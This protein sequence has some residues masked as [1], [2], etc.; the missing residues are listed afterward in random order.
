MRRKKIIGIVLIILL[1]VLVIFIRNY[2]SNRMLYKLE[3]EMKVEF[4]DVDN[5]K[6]SN[7]GPHCTISVYLDEG[8]YKLKD[9]E[10]MFIWTMLELTEEENF[11]YF[12][13]RHSKNATGELAFLHVRF[14]NETGT[15]E[16]LLFK[17][18]SYKDFEIWEL[19]QDKSITYNVSD[20][21]TE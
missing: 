6:I 11:N 7:Y 5:I 4:N 17:F 12:Q 8:A 15:A 20:Y 10:P 18:N 14:Y 2:V 3:A 1:I 16:N 13:E 9:I 21:K 19:E